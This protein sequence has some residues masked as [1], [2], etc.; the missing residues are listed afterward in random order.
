MGSGS[1]IRE[2]IGMIG[3]TG[4]L[5]DGDVRVSSMYGCVNSTIIGIEQFKAVQNIMI[6]C[7]DSDITT[8]FANDSQAYRNVM[9]N[10]KS[11]SIKY[12][13]STYINCTGV[14]G[15]HKGDLIAGDSLSGFNSE[16]D[17][18]C[19]MKFNNGYKF[20]T[21]G[22]LTTGMVAGG[23]ANSFSA[24]CE[25]RL[26][27]N[28][29]EIEYQDIL[30]KVNNLP[31]YKYNYIGNNPAQK[32]IS[33][34][35]EEW[36]EQFG[37][38]DGGLK[39]DKVIESMD[40][41]S[42]ALCSVKA[43]NEQVKDNHGK[44][45]YFVKESITDDLNVL[46]TLEHIQD[47]TEHQLSIMSTYVSKRYTEMDNKIDVLSDKI[48]LIS[49]KINNTKINNTKINNIDASTEILTEIK[50]LKNRIYI[51]ENQH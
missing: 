41:I 47:E 51:L 48:D 38:L 44:F 17:D 5:M 14:T 15:F 1:A 26:K 11:T 2:T 31:L 10:T 49:K 23:G 4:C 8:Q 46:K 33:P 9:I 34:M 27:Q 39:S 20:Y 21:N 29:H 3:C 43:L 6:N 45:E 22:A 7:A 13:D 50:K 19:L 32:N 24:I 36:H 16:S 12:D 28:I 42:I 25:R 30:N 37:F 35:A 40:A 18:Q